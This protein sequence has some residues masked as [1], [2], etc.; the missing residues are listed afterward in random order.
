MKF[1]VLIGIL[2]VVYLLW[3]AKQRAQRGGEDAAN[4]AAPQLPQ[5][6][7]RC[8]VCSVHLPRADALAA[9][10]GQLYCS[11]EHRRIAES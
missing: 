6:M 11:A 3:R 2:A 5:D 1:L 9:G 10:D 7:V 4:T 8:P